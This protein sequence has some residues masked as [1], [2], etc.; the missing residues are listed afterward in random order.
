MQWAALIAW[1]VTAGGG[2]VL[3]VTWLV[4]GGLRQR[5]RGRIRPPLIF[6]Q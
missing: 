2:F 5:E 6:S 1:I 3:L 4:R